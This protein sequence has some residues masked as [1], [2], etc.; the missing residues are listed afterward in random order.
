LRRAIEDAGGLKLVYIDP[1]FDVGADFSYDMFVG[2]NDTDPVTKA[3]TVI[4]DI[5]Y[6]DT[7]GRGDSS[8]IAMLY[9][10]F[11]LIR[12]LLASDGSIYVHCDPRINSYVR[13]ALDEVFGR[14]RFQNEIAWCYTGGRV[15]KVAYG[16]RH[17]TI[18]FYSRS[19]KWTYNWEA[20]TK[21]L[22]D[23]QV[24]RYRYEDEIGKYRL[25]GRF[26]KGSPIKGRVTLI[27]SGR[28]RT[29]N[30]YSDTT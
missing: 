26:L 16:R 12:D 20:V 1:P 9:E 8:F 29:P 6:R 30:L 2:D 28:K 5:A 7:W 21:P 13:L 23:E 15:P 14:D 22:D 25:M 10:R 4:E 24:A 11:V 18:Y 3:P 19:D 17:D 27:Q